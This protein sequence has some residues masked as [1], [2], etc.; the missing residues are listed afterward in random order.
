[1]PRTRI[2]LTSADSLTGSHILYLLLSDG[3]LSVRAI[4][5]SREN[6]S[7]IQEQYR[8]GSSSTVDFTIIQEKDL[9]VPGVFDNALNEHAHPFNTVV[10]TLTA[11]SSDEADCLA[12]FIHLES[13][14]LISFLRSVQQFA[15]QVRRV[16]IV[17]TLTPFARWLQIERQSGRSTGGNR[18][19][20]TTDPE[21]ILATSQAGDNIV[22][23]TVA[24]WTSD[25][26]PQ[27][28]VV[29]ITAPSCY[30]PA[31][32]P[33][34]TSSDLFEA[35]RRIWNICS[36]ERRE[37]METPP[38]GISHFLDVRVSVPY[39]TAD[40][41]NYL[42]F[43]SGFGVCH[44]SCNIRNQRRKQKVSHFSWYHAFYV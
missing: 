27:F 31:L 25:S 4:V 9:V 5:G 11:H 28:D 1:M 18:S 39:D 22:H 32:R 24:K 8:Q 43:D 36:N 42:T 13:E 7:A 3:N 21:S 14:T 10:H 40:L 6:A 15:K 2:L 26:R 30:G 41:V 19:L 34:E 37:R 16:V 12:R 44:F 33:L 38:F 17:A 35:N 23:E 29:Y 20:V